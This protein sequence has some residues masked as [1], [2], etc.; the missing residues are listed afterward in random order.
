LEELV[1]DGNTTKTE[2]K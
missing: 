2:R 1:V